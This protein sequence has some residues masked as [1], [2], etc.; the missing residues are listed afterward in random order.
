MIKYLNNVG[1]YCTDDNHVQIFHYHQHHHY[2]SIIY[3]QYSAIILTDV[4]IERKVL[5]LY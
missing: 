4:S 5:E 2:Y 3:H 1:K